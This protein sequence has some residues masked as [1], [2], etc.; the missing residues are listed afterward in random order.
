[1]RLSNTTTYALKAAIQLAEQPQ[2][3]PV[4]CHRLAKAGEMPER[5][6]LQ[7]LRTLVTHGILVSVRGVAGGYSLLKGASQTSVLEIIEAVEGP[8][9]HEVVECNAFPSSAREKLSGAFENLALSAREQLKSI[10]LSDLSSRPQ[11]PKPSMALAKSEGHSVA[12]AVH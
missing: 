5:F 7:I 4:P 8:M 6:L 3:S 12:V 9:S 1:M 10:K 11:V 2:G